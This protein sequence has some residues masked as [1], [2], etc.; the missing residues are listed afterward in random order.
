M[1]RV[2]DVSPDGTAVGLWG[3]PPEN[4]GRVEVTVEGVKVKIFVPSSKSTVELIWESASDLS[5]RLVSTEGREWPIRLSK[6]KLSSRFDGKYSG[7]SRGSRG[8]GAI[9]YEVTVKESL[10]RGFSRWRAASWRALSGTSS[11]SGITGEVNDHGV[12]LIEIRGPARNSRFSGMFDESSLTATE[13]AD[14]Y[15]QCSFGLKLRR[16]E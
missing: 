12:A 16:T 7:T 6:S 4:R 1:L 11:D 8:C 15:F 14:N 5:G 2:H 9:D 3:I 10:I 13:P